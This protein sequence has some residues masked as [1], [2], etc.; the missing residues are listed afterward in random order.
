MRVIDGGR[1]HDGRPASPLATAAAEGVLYDDPMAKVLG[2]DSDSSST[3][4]WLG[5]GLG[6]VALMLGFAVVTRAVAIFVESTNTRSSVAIPQEID[7]QAEVPPPPPP[8]ATAK[9]EEKPEAPSPKP[10][11]R[12]AP[13]PPAPAQAGKVLTREPDPNEPVDLTGDT[14]V[15]GNAE[16]YA[17]G[18]TARNGTS[19]NAVPK[20]APEPT[21]KPAAGAPSGPPAPDRSRPAKLAGD[22]TW[23]C[24]FPDEANAAQIDEA[25]VA[26]QVDVRP[27]GTPASVRVSKDPGHGFG[28]LARGCALGQHFAPAL[29]RDGHPVA[30]TV[31]FNIHFSR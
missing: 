24:D 4:R 5:Y 13:P 31:P 23:N 3:V 22:S 14:I 20:L 29:D 2:I 19:P 8:A 25:Y 17:G 11:P 27:D 26:I 1:S 12:E 9:P 28:R 16:A 21:A 18:V 6:A 7:V 15:T 30:A 10:L